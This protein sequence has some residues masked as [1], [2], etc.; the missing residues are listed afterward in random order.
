MRATPLQVANAMRTIARGGLYSS[1]RLL[2]DPCGV[3]PETTNLNISSTT[4]AVVYEGMHAVVEESGGTAHKEFQPALTHFASRG[5][6]TYGKTGS[7]TQPE[8]AWFG[9]FARDGSGKAIAVAV[10]VEGGQQGSSDAAPI[11]RDILRFCVDAGY[12]GR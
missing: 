3:Q 6:K 9:G 11:A 12:L 5:I 8:H 7:T 2:A 10:V 4:L 1:P